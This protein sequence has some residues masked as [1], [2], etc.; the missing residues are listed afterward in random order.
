MLVTDQRCINIQ[1]IIRRVVLVNKY[2]LGLL[3]PLLLLLSLATILNDVGQLV[4]M[5]KPLEEVGNCLHDI[6]LV[7]LAHS[8]LLLDRSLRASIVHVNQF[9]C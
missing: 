4:K 8:I 3:E 2:R 5:R 6:H 7:H 1:R 9:L